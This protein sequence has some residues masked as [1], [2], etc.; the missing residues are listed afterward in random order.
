MFHF[1]NY[2]LSIKKNILDCDFVCCYLFHLNSFLKE[3]FV[4]TDFTKQ[5]NPFLFLETVLYLDMTGRFCT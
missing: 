3:S 2:V 1:E 4:N 5:V